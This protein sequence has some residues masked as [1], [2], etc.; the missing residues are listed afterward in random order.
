MS[1][2]SY[3]T[4]RASTHARAAMIAARTL[5]A[6]N[7]AGSFR[8]AAP[9]RLRPVQAAILASPDAHRDQWSRDRMVRL[10]QDHARN[11]IIARVLVRRKSQLVAG[12]RPGL[13]LKSKV[14]A[15]NT[16]TAEWL[17]EWFNKGFDAEGV[18]TF[19][20]FARFVVRNAL[21]Q[22][23]GLAVFLEDGSIQWIDGV[24]IRNPKGRADTE[25]LV[26]GVQ[27]GDGNRIL[28]YW[29]S[30]WNAQGTI[31]HGD[32]EFVAAEDCIYVGNPADQEAGQRRS[33]PGLFAAWARIEDLE[34]LNEAV[35]TSARMAALF[36]MFVTNLHPGVSPF[37]F[38][39]GP[40]GE[41]TAAIDAAKKSKEL[42][43]R[44]GMMTELGPGQD[45]KALNPTQPGP[46]YERKLWADLQLI[47]A[48]IGLPLEMAFYRY[49]NNFSA[50][51]S[52]IVSAWED[53]KVHQA[54]LADCLLTPI[55][56]YR[57]AWGIRTRAIKRVPG[58]QDV[59]W[60]LPGIPT[61]DLAHEVDASA[62]AIA[63]G[64]STRENALQRLDSDTEIDRFYRDRDLEMQEERRIGLQTSLPVAIVEGRQEV[65]TGDQN[66][67][68]DA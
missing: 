24:R 62:R 68:E 12:S 55:V 58:W 8:S 47:C 40:H 30:R 21:T 54:W 39:I 16:E 48:D 3:S 66:D 42:A 52:A 27:L 38:G 5:Q 14:D 37:D 15:W 36:A 1:T 45:I 60:T 10:V 33:E 56:R 64:L 50:G 13:R 31:F 23:D 25:T 63:A 53:V 29:V 59:R 4:T 67:G 41:D 18:L 61:L 43:V 46:Q 57:L 44:P 19:A 65:T 20:Q 28:G 7:V 17:R 51:R 35:N 49:T 9:S 32:S 34:N 6:M 2:R 26:N 11:N 22:G